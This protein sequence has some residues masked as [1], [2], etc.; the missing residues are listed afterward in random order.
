AHIVIESG[1]GSVS[2]L[3]RRLKVGHSRA[4]RL[5]DQLE[6]Y[7]VVGPAQGSK[8]REVTMSKE[9]LENKFSE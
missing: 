3:Q 9:Q 8:P 1:Q 6:E 2:Y 5:M 4:G 7:G